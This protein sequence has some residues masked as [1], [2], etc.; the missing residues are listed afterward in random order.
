M[1][2]HFVTFYS[3]GT[4]FNETSD[5]EIDSWDVNK[6]IEMSHEVTERYGA[7]PYGF[8]FKTRSREPEDLDSHVTKTSGMHHLGGTIKTVE[9]IEKE[10]GDNIILLDN[11]R[12]NNIEKVIENNN[13]WKSIVPFDEGDVLIPDYA[14]RSR[15]KE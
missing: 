5:R 10:G 12:G 1:E 4:F 14:P 3:P 11:M 15:K 7:I 13:S 8:K 6:A 2:K 9:D